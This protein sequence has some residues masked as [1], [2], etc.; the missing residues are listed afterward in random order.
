[1]NEIT[2]RILVVDNNEDDVKDIIRVFRE[3]GEGVI[4][5]QNAPAEGECPSNVRIVILD[6]DLDGCGNVT[7]EDL[8]S[9][10]LVLQRLE[11]RTKFYI[12]ALWSEYIGGT[13]DWATKVT[14]K[15]KEQTGKEFPAHFLKPFGKSSMTQQR[16]VREIRNW[17]KI[18]P[19]AGMIFEWENNIEDSRDDA[20]SDLMD[21]GGVDVVIRSIAAEMG[22]VATPR[23]VANLLNRV[24]LRHAASDKRI[25]KFKPMVDM[26]LTAVPSGGTSIPYDWYTRFQSLQAF[27]PVNKAEPLWTADILE[28]KNA[29][30]PEKKYAVVVTPE[31]DLAQKR[32]KEAKI[33]YGIDFTT[34]PEY[35]STD[36]SVP[37][38]VQV[39]GKTGDN[40]FKKRNE[41][42]KTLATGSDLPE[43]FYILHF[44]RHSEESG[45]YLHL[46]IDFTKINSIACHK[47]TVGNLRV[48]RGWTRLCRLDSP[49]KED[50]LQKYSSYS[51]RLGT[52]SIPQKITSEISRRLK[53]NPD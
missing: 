14:E 4:F 15:Y 52:P 7:D 23:E 47:D 16:L 18:N 45:D 38:V 2:G 26:I 53:Q 46:L 27:F 33:V 12:V 11:S 43:R 24:L 39:F 3:E 35:A 10:V 37:E 49:Y 48:P 13:E 8:A 29:S 42:I 36:E 22:R 25:K 34:I 6:L 19:H 28:K 17:V 50:L 9:V 31:C 21:A 44:F 51:A 40:K 30:D 20:V 41:V 1:M 32:V 5:R